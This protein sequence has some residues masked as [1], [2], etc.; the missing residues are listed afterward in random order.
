L[1]FVVPAVPAAESVGYFVPLILGYGPPGGI[2][3]REC[4]LSLVYFLLSEWW[5]LLATGED[6]TLVF[7]GHYCAL[8]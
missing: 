7:L 3:F 1:F 4:G 2:E 6:V 5:Q 8:S